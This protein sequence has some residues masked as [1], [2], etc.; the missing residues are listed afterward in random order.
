MCSAQRLSILGGDGIQV[1]LDW[2]P[3]SV[4]FDTTAIGQSDAQL[5][6]ITSSGNGDGVISSIEF[7]N[8]VFSVDSA[9]SSFTIAEGATNDLTLVFA[10]TGAGAQSGTATLHTNDP[11]NPRNRFGPQRN[12][13]L[14]SKRRHLRYGVDG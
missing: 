4:V 14:G 1:V 11:S 2:T 3:E 5:V 7:S 8:P 13:Y 10:P 12:R 6:S 9:A